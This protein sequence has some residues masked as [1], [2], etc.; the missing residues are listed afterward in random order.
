[1]KFIVVPGYVTGMFLASHHRICRQPSVS[2]RSLDTSS[3]NGAAVSQP[4]KP[5]LIPQSDSGFLDRFNGTAVSLSLVVQIVLARFNDHLFR[6]R[7]RIDIPRQQMV[8][9]VERIATWLQ[10]IA[11]RMWQGDAGRRI[12]ASG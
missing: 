12:P 2:M 10:P 3:F 4:R 9:W 8:Q 1:M 6:E 7:H 11:E 5:K